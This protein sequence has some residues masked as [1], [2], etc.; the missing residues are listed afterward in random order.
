MFIFIIKKL[1][2]VNDNHRYITNADQNQSTVTSLET[3]C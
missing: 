3:F 1:F 2:I